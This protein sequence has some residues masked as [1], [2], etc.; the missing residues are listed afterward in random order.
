[1]MLSDLVLFPP[2]VVMYEV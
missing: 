2:R 1:M